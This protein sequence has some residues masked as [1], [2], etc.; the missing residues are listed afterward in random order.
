MPLLCAICF[1]VHSTLSR[2]HTDVWQLR[3]GIDER[4]NSCSAPI[5]GFGDDIYQ[6]YDLTVRAFEP[7]ALAKHVQT[8]R[9]DLALSAMM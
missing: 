8:S 5:A 2:R 3:T 4:G 6:H 7:I 1:D 9:P